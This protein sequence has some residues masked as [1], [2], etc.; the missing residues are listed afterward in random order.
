MTDKALEI[1]NCCCKIIHPW[2]PKEIGDAWGLTGE[3]IGCS[4]EDALRKLRKKIRM[5][6]KG[7]PLSKSITPTSDRL[8]KIVKGRSQNMPM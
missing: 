1:R 3:A 8:E 6:R 7:P 2:T 4:E 5:N